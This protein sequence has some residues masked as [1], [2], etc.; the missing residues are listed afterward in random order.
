[1]ITTIRNTLAVTAL[2][3]AALSFGLR[4]AHAEDTT[5][6]VSTQKARACHHCLCPAPKPVADPFADMI[7]G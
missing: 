4:I 1:M 3:L 6:E 7:L 2:A 5:I